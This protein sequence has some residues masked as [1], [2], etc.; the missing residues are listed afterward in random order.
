MSKRP[1]DVMHLSRDEYEALEPWLDAGMER[2]PFEDLICHLPDGAVD[3]IEV[4]AELDRILAEQ[5]SAI[6]CRRR[7]KKKP[8]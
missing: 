6:D 2:E 4:E 7:E 1:W 5:E 3:L 8:R